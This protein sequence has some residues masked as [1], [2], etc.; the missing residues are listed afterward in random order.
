MLGLDQHIEGFRRGPILL[1]TS[2]GA[3]LLSFR[4]C[5]G[6]ALSKLHTVRELAELLIIENHTLLSRF[7]DVCTCIHFFL[8]LPVTVATSERSFSKLKFI[9]NYLRSTMLVERLSGLANL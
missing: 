7:P 4:T 6:P 5:M 8:T 9:K 2:F 1:N 3:Q